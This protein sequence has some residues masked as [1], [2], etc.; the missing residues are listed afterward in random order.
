MDRWG[1][2]IDLSLPPLQDH[3]LRVKPW[4]VNLLG[5]PVGGG[6]GGLNPE[7]GCLTRQLS[8]AAEP[9]RVFF[10]GLFLFCQRGK[11]RFVDARV[12]AMRW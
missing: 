8:A 11:R 10:G 6:W 7:L 9:A 3:S 4:K 2:P 5:A 1:A 12:T